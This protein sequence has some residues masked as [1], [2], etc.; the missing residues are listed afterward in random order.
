MATVGEIDLIYPSVV[1]DDA[2][3]RRCSMRSFDFF[4]AVLGH[5]AV[6][7]QKGGG[8]E[9]PPVATWSSEMSIMNEIRSSAHRSLLHLKK[10]ELATEWSDGHAVVEIQ[11]GGG[12]EMTDHDQDLWRADR[13]LHEFEGVL[14]KGRLAYAL[15]KGRSDPPYYLPRRSQ[16]WDLTLFKFAALRSVIVISDIALGEVVFHRALSIASSLPVSSAQGE[17]DA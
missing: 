2:Y 15:V 4:C 5:A 12:C 14:W 6:E 13:I 11:K 8:C 1:L 3:E 7:I 9:M 10:D 17:C 16:T